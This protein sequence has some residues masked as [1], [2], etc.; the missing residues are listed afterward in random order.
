V[1][2]ELVFAVP[3]DL[4]TPTGGYAYDRRIIG[5]LERL[6]WSVTVLDLGD[7]FPRPL[8]S[9]RARALTQLASV[10]AGYPVIIDGLALGALP[11]IAEWLG[12][13]TLIALVHHPLALESGL[14]AGEAQALHASERAA[15]SAVRG[16]VTVSETIARLIVSDYGTPPS[17]ITIAPPGI[18]PVVAADRIRSGPIALLAVGAIVPRK[19]YDVLLEALAEIRDLSW[20][21]SIVG[22]RERDPATAARLDAGLARHG[23]GDR[24]S[25]LGAVPEQRLDALH[26]QSDLFVLA[27]R[28]EGYGMAF[29]AAIAHGLPV[30]GT[31]AGAIAETVREAGLLVPP[32]DVG[33]LAGALRG[34]IGDDAA[35]ARLA[36][37]ARGAARR[38]P[39]WPQS[40]KLVARA[41][42]AAIAAR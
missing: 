24:I 25:V 23:L 38:L 40:G 26:A 35:R 14:A 32:D 5:E 42:E 17:R 41:V 18:D 36:A 21:L 2:R 31:R 11:E 3:G 28:F 8:P 1:K 9:V 13:A 16:V 12:R 27:S 10:P 19:G 37:R 34:L 7:G 33:A 29:A 39:T 4:S 30:I 22:D 20:R 6:G 15:L